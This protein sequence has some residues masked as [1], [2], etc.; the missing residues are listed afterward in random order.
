MKEPP[1]VLS[2]FGRRR[3]PVV[4]QSEAA[5][6]GLACLAM[7]A[8]YHGL[9]TDLTS[10]R[11][12]WSLSQKG[13]TLAHLIGMARDLH[14]SPRALRLEL[15]DLPALVRPAIL[16]WDLDHFVVLEQVARSHIR[17]VDPA[18]GRRRVPMREVSRRFTGVALEL[19][20]AAG[21]QRRRDPPP[22]PLS[23]FITG[24]RGLGAALLR[25]LLLS[26]ALQTFALM[27]PL[28][29]Q[30]VIDE[31]AVSGDRNLLAILGVAFLLLTGIHVCVAGVRGWLVATLAATL[32]YAWGARLFHHLLRLPLAWFEKRHMGD[33]VSRFQSLRSIEALV[34]GTVVEA[35]V[36]GVMAL[37]ALAVMGFYSL[38]LAG[39]VVAALLLYIGVRAIL[40]GPLRLATFETLVLDAR[41]DSIFMESVRAIVPIKNYTRE[42]YRE[43][44]WQNRRA[45]AL[46]AEL[47]A[48]R[49]ELVQQ[50][51][52][53]ALFGAENV[54]V[55]WAGALAI[56][57]NELSVGMLVAFLAYKEQF[58]T[59]AAALVDRALEFRLV[60]LHLDRLADIALAERDRGTEVPSEPPHRIS[61]ALEVRNLWF[62][63]SDTEP[64]L[65]AGLDFSIAPGERVA[66]TAPSGTGKTTLLKLMMGLLEPSSGRILVD[67]LDVR[68]V[69]AGY[70][71]QIAAVMQEDVLLAGTLADNITF[72]D[73]AP[74]RAR[75]EACAR[76]AAIH[77]D[78]MRM[79]MGYLTPVGDMGSTLSGGQR[80]RICLARALYARPRILFLDEATS[81]LDAFTEHRIHEALR[82]LNITCVMVAHRRETLSIADRVIRLEMPDAGTSKPARPV[83]S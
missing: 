27:L 31:I 4:L 20:P 74:D 26:A 71:R 57:E 58:G 47:R 9:K 28:F 14:L 46:N 82:E 16:H 15:Q 25:I 80:Q 33:I 40:F 72:F 43:T 23:A 17:I 1:L 68:R 78:V 2:F 81:H 59:R 79:P 37:A 32:R 69:L 60:G 76:A 13:I 36:D 53:M 51:A 61:G 10:L 41:V 44:V 45:E 35:I 22:L 50:L 56:L 38:K 30:I 55:L 63:Y 54:A 5:E 49:L 62:R 42:G 34:A 3:V 29:G 77:E 11:R 64:Y 24:A 67:G 12:R 6:C 83:T 70:R 48:H 8:G 18:V 73:P 75:M 66:I 39:I 21:F 65:F 7:V 19:Q 52:N